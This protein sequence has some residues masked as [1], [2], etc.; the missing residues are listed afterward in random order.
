MLCNIRKF[1]LLSY[2]MLTSEKI[3]LL[4]KVNVISKPQWA[5]EKELCLH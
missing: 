3:A 2:F 1:P 4:E 5:K